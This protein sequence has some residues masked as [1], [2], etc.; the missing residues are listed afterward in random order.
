MPGWSSALPLL[1]SAYTVA[2]PLGPTLQ[3]PCDSRPLQATSI[4]QGSRGMK[5]DIDDFI[6]HINHNVGFGLLVGPINLFIAY[7]EDN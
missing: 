3:Q 5:H 2:T 6:V 7:A 4:N 1:V